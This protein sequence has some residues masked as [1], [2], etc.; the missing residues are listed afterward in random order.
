M[1]VEIDITRNISDQFFDFMGHLPREDGFTILP[2]LGTNEAQ[3]KYVYLPGELEFYHFGKTQFKEAISMRTINPADTDWFL[4]HINLSNIPQQKEVDGEMLAFHK[5][6]PIGLLLYGPQLEIRTQFPIGV[7]IEVASIRF[8]TRF[9]EAYFGKAK[10]V[11]DLRR[12]LLCEDLDLGME[13]IF[14]AA[15]HSMDDKIRCHALLLKFLNGFFS[16]ISKHEKN[17]TGETIHAEDLKNI[18]EVSSYLR[19]PL[20]V[21]TPKVA[22]LAEMAHMGLTKFKALFKK[23]FGQAPMEY[24]NRIRMEYA[25]RMLEMKRR[26]PGE[27]SYELGYSHPS[28]FTTAYK[29]H[30]GHLPSEALQ[31]SDYS[32]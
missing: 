14:M 16:K 19:D 31:N 29:K 22:E 4:I 9:L 24:R 15:L 30:F 11:I 26:N 2:E 8:N 17:L 32:Q 27:L 6:L 23:V 12:N 10:D 28:N 20:V 1:E 18:L 3:I 7:D 13:K 5:D 25:Q 21:E